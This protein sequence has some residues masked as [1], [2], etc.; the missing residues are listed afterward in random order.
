MILA[1]STSSSQLHVSYKLDVVGANYMILA[2]S[3]MHFLVVSAPKQ[4]GPLYGPMPVKTE[5]FREL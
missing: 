5:T 1:A 3:N 4:G 2:V